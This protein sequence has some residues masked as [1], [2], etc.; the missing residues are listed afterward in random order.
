M[1]YRLFYRD[2]LTHCYQRTED[3]G[4][5]FYTIS[6]FLV[7]FTVYCL[8]ARK[9]S[10]R[11]FALCQM[12]DHVHDSVSSVSKRNLS[13][14]KCEVNR[15]F[16]RAWNSCY[17]LT[18]PVFEGRFGSAPKPGDKKARTNLIY[19]NNNPVERRLVNRAIEYRWNYLAYGQTDYAF[20]DRLVIRNSSPAMKRAVKEVRHTFIAGLPMNYTLLKRLFGTLDRREGLQLTDYIISLYNVIEYDSASRFFG[21]FENMVRAI[22]SSTGS[23][24]DLNEIFVGKSDVCYGQM[25]KVLLKDLHLSDVHDILSKSQ[26]EKFELFRH[27]MH[28]TSADPKQIAKFLHLPVIDKKP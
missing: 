12:P 19:V 8:M 6:D 9:Y 17:G 5:L 16:S 13:L 28:T 27:L 2:I 3:R 11:V 7:Y 18:G 26:D 14:F 20:S 15:R 23:E 24:Y 25:T 1:K 22:D 10:I 21:G 4:V